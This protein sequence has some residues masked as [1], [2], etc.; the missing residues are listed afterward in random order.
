[1]ER[2]RK[3]IREVPLETFQKVG[4]GCNGRGGGVKEKEKGI[5]GK[6]VYSPEDALI[7]HYII[8]LDFLEVI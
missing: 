4:R 7:E 5:T 1:M 3:V 8:Y 6:V 2:F